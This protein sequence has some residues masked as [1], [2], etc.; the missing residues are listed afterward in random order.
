MRFLFW[1]MYRI[2]F[3]PWDRPGTPAPA[4]LR[5]GD[6]T[7]IDKAGV[8][9][10]FDFF[11]D[12]GCFHGMSED[13][14][15]HYSRSLTQVAAP[16]AEILL[17]S[18]GPSTSRIPPRGAE[19]GDVERCFADNWSIFWSVIDRDVPDALAGRHAFTAW[20]RLKRR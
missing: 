14:R 4:V 7:H 3:T 5:R 8:S 1:L 2:D 9:G 10:P 15:R 6:V 13:E 20:Y 12:G 18:F 11:L 17:F 19:I 16:D